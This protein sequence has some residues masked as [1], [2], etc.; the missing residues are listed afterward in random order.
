MAGGDNP[1]LPEDTLLT[2][3]IEEVVVSVGRF[4]TFVIQV[5]D[6]MSGSTRLTPSALVGNLEC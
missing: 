3:Y 2:Q 4:N 1:V 5:E 6:D